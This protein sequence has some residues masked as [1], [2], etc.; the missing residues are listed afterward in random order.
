M[1]TA[2][3]AQM[4]W[5]SCVSVKYLFCVIDA[6]TK[7]AWVKTFKDKKGKTIL[8]G[9]FKIVNESQRKPNKL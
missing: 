2:D 5:L 4:E 6:F 3:V 8:N 1:L 7:Y 9:L